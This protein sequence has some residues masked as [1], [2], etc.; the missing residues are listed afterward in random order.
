MSKTD[1][2]L[3]GK[4]GNSKVV[5][6]VRAPCLA[7]RPVELFIKNQRADITSTSLQGGQ[8]V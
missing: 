6:K 7:R 4:Y 2:F 3:G 1:E 8:A 5:S